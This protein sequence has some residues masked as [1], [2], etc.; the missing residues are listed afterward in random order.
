MSPKKRIFSGFSRRSIS[1]RRFVA[2]AD[3]RNDRHAHALPV[4]AQQV[5]APVVVELHRHRI[6]GK[7]AEIG[8]HDRAEV[9]K[10]LRVTGRIF[11]DALKEIVVDEKMHAVSGALGVGLCTVERNKGK[12]PVKR[13]RR[14][15][16]DAVGAV[17]FI[18]AK[19]QVVPVSLQG[20]QRHRFHLPSDRNTPPPAVNRQAVCSHTGSVGH[21]P[22]SSSVKA[23]S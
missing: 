22:D 11:P 8:R 9:H 4:R 19:L 23:G 20:F 21:A 18:A 5:L 2:P 10:H 14:K 3:R 7:Q 17:R 6:V 13:C 16:R 1:L 15:A 12:R